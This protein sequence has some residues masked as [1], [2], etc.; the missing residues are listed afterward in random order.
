MTGLALSTWISRTR[1]EPAR[2]AAPKDDWPLMG[3]LVTCRA[4]VPEALINWRK[5]R[6]EALPVPPKS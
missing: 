4:G 1:D 3:D 6:G 2:P 5:A